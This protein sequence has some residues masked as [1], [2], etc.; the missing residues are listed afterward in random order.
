MKKHRV[1]PLEVMELEFLDRKIVFNFNMRAT[2]KMQERFGDIESA[3]KGKDEYE[4]AAMMLWAGVKDDDFS[5]EE[6]EVIVTSSADALSDALSITMD[7][8]I[9]LAGEVNSK[10][11]QEEIEKALMKAKNQ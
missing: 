5:L 3:I 8:I 11:I 10:K 2:T 4:I 9:K 7:S 6:A 1:T